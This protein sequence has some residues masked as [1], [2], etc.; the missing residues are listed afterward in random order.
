MD[1]SKRYHDPLMPA[2]A[3]SR[4]SSRVKRTSSTAKKG[5][6]KSRSS[7]AGTSRAAFVE[8]LKRL[9]DSLQSDLDH[10]LVT[11]PLDVA[12]LTGFL[13]G[14]SYLLLGKSGITILSD[15]RYEEELAPLSSLAKIH[16]RTGSMVEAVGKVIESSNV[17][18]CGV[19]SEYVSIAELDSLSAAAK[20]SGATL[21]PTKG[22]LSA[23]RA[24]KDDSEVRLIEAAIKIQEAALLATLPTVAAG[25][26]EADIAA[27]LEMEMKSRGSREPG[28]QTIVAA[29]AN[30]SLP[31]YRPSSQVKL[32]RNQPVLIDWG[33]TCLGYHG[34]MTRTFTLGKWPAKIREIYQITLDAQQM[35]AQALAPGK[36][37]VE[38]DSIART[39]I[40]AHGYGKNFGHGLG[41]GLGFNGH[42]DPRL[43]HMLPATELQVGQVVTIEPGIYLPGVGGVRIED[44]YLI[45]RTGARNLCSLP[46][47]IE[48]CTLG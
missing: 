22:L 31:H 25:K 28:F 7:V 21:Q 10:L 18:R 15:F 43:S 13:G 32:A 17:R 48:W 19:Q 34:D 36:T 1:R 47:D 9:G 29:R 46:K 37:T 40:A 30:G 42:E 5:G 8:R 4:R 20:L 44:D 6:A 12:Y 2:K 39:Y 41:H 23:M 11:N 27:H 24:I 38:I 14:D 35:A 3:A 16:I 33:A 26:S 45:T